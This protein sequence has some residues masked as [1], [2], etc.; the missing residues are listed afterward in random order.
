MQSKFRNLWPA[1]I[2]AILL[3][4]T[5]IYSRVLG[6][7]VSQPNTSNLPQQNSDLQITRSLTDEVRLLRLSIERSQTNVVIAQGILER[8]RIQQ[9][10]VNFISQRLDNVRNE[11]VSSQA[12][13]PK[14]SQNILDAENRIKSEEDDKAKATLQRE[15]KEAQ[16][17]YEQQKILE[18]Q[19][20]ALADNLAYQL[21]I[22]QGKLDKLNEQFD[23]MEQ[24]MKSQQ[25]QSKQSSDK[26][27]R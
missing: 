17:I 5:F 1:V 18:G 26:V 7:S 15:Y 24:E 21:Q 22:E 8:I 14:L 23:K 16:V 20:K 3:M 6:H 11:I 10:Q 25:L 9:E 12:N 13:L 4:G 2:Y 19:Q 27:N